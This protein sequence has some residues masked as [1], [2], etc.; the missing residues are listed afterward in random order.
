MSLVARFVRNP[1]KVSV[2][3]LLVALFGVIGAL[4]MPMQLTPEVQIPSLTIETRW[5][6]ASPQEVEQEIIQEQEEQLKSVEGVTKLSSESMDSLGRIT[7]EFAIGTDMDEA[8]LKVNSRLQQV[9]QYPENADQP[10]I[11]TSNSANTPIAWFILSARLPDPGQIAAFQAEHPELREALEPVRRCHNAG[12]AMLR[13][14]ELAKTHPAVRALLP[15]EIDVTKLRRFAEDYIESAFERVPGVAN[16]NVIGGLEDEL[17]VV[18]DP[19]QLAARQLTILDVRNVLRNQ[20]RDTSGGDF[21]EGKRRWVVRTL[22]QFRSKEQVASQLLAVRDGKPVYIRDVATVRDGFKKPDGLVRR[23]GDSSIA[24]NCLRDNNANVLEVMAGLRAVNKKLNEGLLAQRGLQLIQVYDETE[25]IY[26]AISLVRENIFLGG[27]LTM[28]VL[29]A[30]LHLNRRTL[31]IAPLILGLGLASVYV[32]PWFFP[33]CLAVI[34][35]AG[36]WYARGALVI[37]LAIPA[38]IVGTFLIL[39]LLGRTLNVISLAGL[40]FA[41]GMLVDN[42]VVILENIYSRYQNGEDAFTATVLGTEEVWGAVVSSTLTTV[43]VFVPVLFVQE[44]AGQLFRDIALAISAAVGLSLIVSVVIV[45]TAATRIIRRGRA[46]PLTEAPR[47]LARVL[48]HLGDRFIGAVTWINRGIQRHWTTQLL[49]VAVF[50]AGCA[51]LAYVF[52]P[53]VEYLP[54]GNRNLVFG[55]LL[56]PPGY[57]LDEL[58][59]M[60]QFAEDELRPYWDIDA[61]EIRRQAASITVWDR[62]RYLLTGAE[63][64]AMKLVKRPAIGDFFFVARGRQ[65]F[66]GVRSLDPTRAAEMIPLV[67][68]L[69]ARLPGTIAVAF[70]S[71]LFSQGLVA[72]R[73][74]DIEI[75]GPD[76]R[77]LVQLGVR[78]LAGDP[79]DTPGRLPSIMEVI[80]NGQARP[81]PSLDLSSPEVHVTPR[82]WQSAEMELSASELGY[83]VDALVDG[84]YASDYFL[85]AEKIDLTIRG[86]DEFAQKTQDIGSLPVAVR[87]GQLVPL[88]A[89]ADIQLAS[90]PEQVNHR[91]RERAITIAV[92]PPPDMSLEDAL[93]RIQAQVIAPLERAGVLQDGYRITLAGT[94]DKLKET[95]LALRF[96]LLLALLITY[97]LLA[98]LYESWIY[99]FVIIFSVPLG[100]VG[101]LVGLKLLNWY[102]VLLEQPP[103][104]LDVLT[105]LGF[106]IL[107]GTVV[108]NAILVVDQALQ[109]IRQEGYAANAAIVEGVRSRIRPMFMTTITTVLG[110]LPLV[111]FPG[112]GSEL[113]RGLGSVVLCGLS[114]STLFT[115]FLVPAAFTLT[116]N[117][118]HWFRRLLWSRPEHADESNGQPSGERDVKMALAAKR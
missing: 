38:S 100:A 110:L 3:V 16:S 104:S 74:I 69:G 34:V 99:P 13:L 65:V 28:T 15:A 47:G 76:L 101:G 59:R 60:G 51:G 49:T 68:S 42:A 70:Q 97:L 23:F 116:W 67:R 40:A 48:A 17:Q 58:T 102:L 44:E 5:P 27:A 56:P 31:V 9:P 118:E 98:A 82:L 85:G 14:R 108:N 93:Q 91:E 84:A 71:S 73:T 55:I 105:M 18:V 35:G 54:N 24:I 92:T 50:V 79:P 11:S 33:V 95:W 89:V 109:L 90:G 2:G 39:S 87:S 103:Q 12:L 30:F 96:N 107:I 21:W 117:L 25:Y 36:F 80:P 1:V 83:T 41:V 113:Y 61:E 43:A 52:W 66:I 7:M 106:V 115:L 53:Q 86:R 29:M 112:A 111:L 20:N 77:R 8:L 6:G 63:T 19:E 4:Q 10:V 78:I 94:A 32:S 62:V 81:V 64:P 114:L 46:A 45:P 57:N 22:G 72:G 37:G 88:A 26:S 75:T